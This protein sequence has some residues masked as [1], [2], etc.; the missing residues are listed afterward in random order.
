[1]RTGQA[2]P[3]G[4]AKP[5]TGIVSPPRWGQCIVLAGGLTPDNVADAVRRVRPHGVDVVVG[6]EAAK[7]IKDPRKIKGLH[8]R[9]IKCRK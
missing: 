8:R 7:G 9:G 4:R 3:A 2:S 6:V 1:M 5:S